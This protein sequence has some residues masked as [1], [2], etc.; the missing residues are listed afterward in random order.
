LLLK[1]TKF[2]TGLY[3]ADGEVYT[4]MLEIIQADTE[5]FKAQIKLNSDTDVY[6]ELY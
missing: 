3:R 1:D 4:L 5:V 6:A 2:Y